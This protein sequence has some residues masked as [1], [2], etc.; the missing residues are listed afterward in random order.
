MLVLTVAAAIASLNV[1]VTVVAVATPV[2][3]AAGF[4]LTTVGGVVSEPP[5]VLNTTS[6]Q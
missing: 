1:A 6:T 5:V 4:L 3:P 2:A